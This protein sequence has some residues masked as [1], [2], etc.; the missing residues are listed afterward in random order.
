MDT[1]DKLARD[2]AA[3]TTTG[4]GLGEGVEWNPADHAWQLRVPWRAGL[5]AADASPASC[6]F[7]PDR[8][9]SPPADGPYVVDSRY[10]FVAAPDEGARPTHRV[11]FFSRSHTR[12]LDALTE[13]ELTAVL[14]CVSA[15]STELLQHE[16][17][18]SV[19]A[20]QASGP[21]FGGSVSHPHLQAIGLPFV[22]R[23]L[24]LDTVRGCPLCAGFG[25]SRCAVA[26]TRDFVLAVPPWSRLPYEMVLAP[27]RHLGDADPSDTA[28]IAELLS[29]GLRAIRGLIPG[30]DTPYMIGIMG[31]PKDPPGSY[32]P[33]DHHFRIEILPFCTEAGRPRQVVAIEF[34]AGVVL[35]PTPPAAAAGRLRRAVPRREN[36]HP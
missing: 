28:Q 34:G 20:F 25:E 11:V 32:G 22:P 7:C 14:D 36:G 19:Y 6:P 3:A 18:R 26:E 16:A 24:V 13:P 12:N 21:L 27:R 1:A 9:Q 15:L 29:R 2:A 31:A 4:P 23:K 10:P 5:P 17:I 30:G 8:P 35:N 33:A